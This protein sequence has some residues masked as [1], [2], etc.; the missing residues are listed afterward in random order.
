MPE[1]TA[2]SAAG[3]PTT[4]LRFSPQLR[5]LL[6]AMIGRVDAAAIAAPNEAQRPGIKPADLPDPDLDAAWAEGLREREE[7]DTRALLGLVMNSNFG[8]ADLPLTPAAAE[9]IARASVRVRL[10]LRETLLRDLNSLEVDGDLDV[11]RLPPPEQQ[12]YACFRLLAHL[13]EDLIV[14]LDPGLRKG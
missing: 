12:G 3:R 9:A 6:A 8:A 13:E 4:R 10:H 14:Q 11:F 7:Y 2:P 1:E 5:E